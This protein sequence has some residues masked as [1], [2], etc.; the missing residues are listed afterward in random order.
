MLVRGLSRTLWSTLRLETRLLSSK[1]VNPEP[2][3]ETKDGVDPVQAES[4]DRDICLLVDEKDTFIGTATK[5]E[6]HK[7]APDGSIPLHRAFSVFL[8]NKRGD[9]LLQRRSSQK[10]TYPDYYTNACCSHPLFI[11]NQQ[12]DVITAARRRLNLE[13]GIPLNQMEPEQFTFLT[14]IHYHDPGDGVWGEHEVDHILVLQADVKIKP[15]SDEISE[16]CFVP[17]NEFNSFL[18]TLEGPITP[19]FNMVR[20]HRLKL[21]WDNLHRIKELAQ[22][23]KIH[24]FKTDDK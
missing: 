11:D 7:V 10:V 5:R 17:K 9:M 6:C 12:E 16:Y 4:L 2:A 22:P 13:L 18:P 21:W 15:N 3:I 1:T 23:D 20:R 19:W 8:F 14:R 24:K